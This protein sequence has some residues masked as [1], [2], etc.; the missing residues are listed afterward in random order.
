RGV[1][2]KNAG[3]DTFGARGCVTLDQ[4]LPNR[5]TIE[6]S[7][8]EDCGLAAISVKTGEPK[9]ASL[10]NNVLRRAPVGL[11]LHVDM[12]D[13]AVE[14]AAYE[15]VPVNRIDGGYV[16]KSATWTT[17]PMPWEVLDSIEVSSDDTPVLTLAAGAVLRFDQG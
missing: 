10:A 13:S 11:W 5:V 3:Q 12:V 2:V 14:Q 4:V 17:Q 16:T 8:F 6:D 9:L 1:T 15:D 7:I